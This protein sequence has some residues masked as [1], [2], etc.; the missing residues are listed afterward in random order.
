[1]VVPK[2]DASNIAGLPG[3]RHYKSLLRVSIAALRTAL[4]CVAGRLGKGEEAAGKSGNLARPR[5][6]TH[7]LLDMSWVHD[8]ALG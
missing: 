1:M 5:L 6:L 2:K 8:F 4:A 3:G 7:A